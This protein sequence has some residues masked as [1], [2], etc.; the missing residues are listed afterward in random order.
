MWKIC[1]LSFAT[2]PGIDA[3]GPALNAAHKL[4]L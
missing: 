2:I 3:I 4:K 1:Y